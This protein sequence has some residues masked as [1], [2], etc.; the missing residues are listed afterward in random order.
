MHACMYHVA[1]YV[2][3]EA[4]LNTYIASLIEWVRGNSDLM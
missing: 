1:I 2:Y 3:V 4:T